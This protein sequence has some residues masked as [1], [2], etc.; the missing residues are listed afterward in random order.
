ML[1]IAHGSLFRS[2]ALSDADRLILLYMGADV[3]A[4]YYIWRVRRVSDVFADF[5]AKPKED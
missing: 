2:Y 1:S 5:P 3:L 4:L